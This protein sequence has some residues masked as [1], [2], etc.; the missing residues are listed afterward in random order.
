MISGDMQRDSQT[1]WH[2][3]YWWAWHLVILLIGSFTALLL[4]CTSLFAC[5]PALCMTVRLSAL[6][7]DNYACQVQSSDADNNTNTQPL[8][9]LFLLLTQFFPPRFLSLVRYVFSR[10]ESYLL[11]V[12]CYS[13]K[14]ELWGQTRAHNSKYR[15][16]CVTNPHTSDL[17]NLIRSGLQ[18]HILTGSHHGEQIPAEDSTFYLFLVNNKQTKAYLM[19]LTRE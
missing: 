10:A 12:F 6:V 7:V 15:Q 5:C 8:D 3:G 11:I 19:D 2:E 16:S 1:D 9:S 14:C 17:I 4:A 13:L 18:C